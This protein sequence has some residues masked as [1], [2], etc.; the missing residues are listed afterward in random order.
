MAVYK[1]RF[2]T[3]DSN[4]V[5][6]N[7][8]LNTTEFTVRDDSIVESLLNVLLD[9]LDAGLIDLLNGLGLGESLNF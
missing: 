5:T 6:L 9:D 2:R 8:A 3:I 4:L 7:H 1:T